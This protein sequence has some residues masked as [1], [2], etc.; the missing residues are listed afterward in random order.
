MKILVV[1]DDIKIASFIQKGL[2]EELYSVDII[3]DGADA[4]YLAKLH[5]YDIILLDIMIPTID[6]LT[7]CKR[8]R[9]DGLSVPIIILSARNLLQDKIDGLDNGANDYLTKPF[10]FEELLARVRVQLRDS[11][12]SSNIIM[13]GDLSID[14][15]HRIVKRNNRK[16]S[17]TAKEYTLLELLVR[18]RDKILTESVIEENL[19]DISKHTISNIINVYIYRL[20]NKIDKGYS[21]KLIH[22]VHG[23]GYTLSVQD[24]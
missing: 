13:V 19:N 23:I 8:L 16:I 6:G 21:L 22:T 2:E 4:L 18:N 7:V 9:D 14:I 24:V 12:K 5:R 10:A 3:N 15:N 11:N 20:R 1:E 17:L